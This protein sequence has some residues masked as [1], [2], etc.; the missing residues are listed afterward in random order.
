MEME[1]ECPTDR[2]STEMITSRKL[3][4]ERGSGKGDSSRCWLFGQRAERGA[5]RHASQ[6][7]ALLNGEQE[8]GFCPQRTNSPE[9]TFLSNGDEFALAKGSGEAFSEATGQPAPSCYLSD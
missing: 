5:S 6:L 1:K 7:W 2:R 3:N 9:G 8:N 4:E